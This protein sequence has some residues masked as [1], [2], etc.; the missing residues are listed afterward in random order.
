MAAP[1]W[2][3][4]DWTLQVPAGVSFEEE[5]RLLSSFAEGAEAAGCRVV[6]LHELE[7]DTAQFADLVIER[8]SD[9]QRLM[10]GLVQK[11]KNDPTRIDVLTRPK[12]GHA[13]LLKRDDRW[14]LILGSSFMHPEPVAQLGIAGLIRTLLD[15]RV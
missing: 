1:V 2:T 6:P 14:R 7:F 11:A 10:F 12:S 9:H 5:I 15:E 3:V 8:K 4:P 13:M